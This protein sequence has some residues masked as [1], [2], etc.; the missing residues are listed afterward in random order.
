MEANDDVAAEFSQQL[1][2]NLQAN[3]ATH[4]TAGAVSARATGERAIHP[5]RDSGETGRGTNSE[6]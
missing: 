3:K 5:H 1:S 4:A 2:R 6:Y